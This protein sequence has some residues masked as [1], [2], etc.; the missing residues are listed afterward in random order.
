MVVLVDTNSPPTI[1]EI[2]RVTIF[3]HTKNNVIF[4]NFPFYKLNEIHLPRPSVHDL[5]I[6][7]QHNVI[8]TELS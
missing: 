4:L 1:Y 8:G 2:S 3:C 5:H 6:R 7:N